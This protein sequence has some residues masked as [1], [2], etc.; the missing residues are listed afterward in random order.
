MTNSP[1]PDSLDR[2]Q[3]LLD[4]AIRFYTALRTIRLY[5]PTNP[6]VLRSNEAVIQ[7]FQTLLETTPDDAVILAVSDRKLLICGEHL[8]DKEQQ[9]PQVQGLITLF[10]RAK[11]HSLAFLA[12]FSLTECMALSQTLSALLGEKEATET[13]GTLLDRAGIVSVTVDA[14][15]YVA[16]REGE[17]V[18]REEL[19]GAGLHVSDEELAN[20]VLGRQGESTAVTGVS[21]ELVQELINRLPAT[22]ETGQHPEG[23]TE[24]VIDFLQQLRREQDQDKRSLDITEGGGTLSVLDPSLLAQL[25]AKLPDSTEADAVLGSALDQLP[26]ERINALIGRLVTQQFTAGDGSVQERVATPT[27][28]QRLINLEQGRQPEITQTIAQNIDARSLLLTADHLGRAARTS[29][30]PA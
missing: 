5:P 20:F 21:R 28:L 3:L 10:S 24:A 23:V 19:L 1:P 26:P 15:R 29:A 6:Q 7:S 16:I 12:T 9:R 11:I 27:A 22:G 4:F 25:I 8:A 2:S 17:Q 18:V 13:V 14:Q 30:S